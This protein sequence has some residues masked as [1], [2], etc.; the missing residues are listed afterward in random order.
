VQAGRDNFV[1]RAGSAL[2]L[3]HLTLFNVA[4]YVVNTMIGFY[5]CMGD[6]PPRRLSKWGGALVTH[7][8]RRHGSPLQFHC[9]ACG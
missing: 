6:P 1:V 8:A 2:D 5:R 7:I 9:Q 4:A 3:T